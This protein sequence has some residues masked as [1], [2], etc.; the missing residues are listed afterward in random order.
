MGDE[1][2]EELFDSDAA[3]ALGI[4]INPSGGG[5]ECP[6]C[7]CTEREVEKTV[8]IKNGIRRYSHCAFCGK[9]FTTIERH[10][11]Y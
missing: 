1:K 3:R 4:K 5:M 6:Q 10:G 9:K 11:A 7:G 2:Q 8:R